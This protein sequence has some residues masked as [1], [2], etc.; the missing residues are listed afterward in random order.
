MT[1]VGM[2][3]NLSQFDTT[4]F[5]ST[6]DGGGKIADFAK[7]RA[8]FIQGDLSDAVFYIRKGKVAL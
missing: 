7:R 5:L 3:R 4:T 1:T 2:A 8:I 6:T